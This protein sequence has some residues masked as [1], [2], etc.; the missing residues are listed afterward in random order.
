MLYVGDE[1]VANLQNQTLGQAYTEGVMGA[2]L[3]GATNFAAAVE[4][5]LVFTLDATGSP[6]PPTPSL[7]INMGCLPSEFEITSANAGLSTLSR[8]F[9]WMPV[10]DIMP[11]AGAYVGH[12]VLLDGYLPL[13]G[14]A[15]TIV[16]D[17]VD[18]L[19]DRKVDVTL[20]IP[21]E[22]LITMAKTPIG[23][24]ARS[25]LVRDL[26]TFVGGPFYYSPVV[27]APATV[28][29]RLAVAP[30]PFN[31][32]TE[33]F[34]TL[35]TS[36]KASVKVYDVRGREVRSL[37]DGMLEGGIEHR[38]SWDGRDD[39]GRS[40]ASGVYFVAVDAPEFQRRHKVA[41]IK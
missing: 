2:A 9:Q 1:L 40:L 3:T 41:L 29:N 20:T 31:P 10:N 4:A 5:G 7:G 26:L 25:M 21:L 28:K 13:G 15:G 34:L 38:L 16:F 39:N 27:D 19:G 32:R 12:R 35:A 18:G 8:W 22:Q 30:N 6:F 24:S 23:P 17:R 14:V 37:H 33:V 11:L 36:A